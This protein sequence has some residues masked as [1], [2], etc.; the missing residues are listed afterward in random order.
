M[1]V[2]IGILFL[3]VGALFISFQLASDYLFKQTQ[4]VDYTQKIT[5]EMMA[6]NEEK[7]VKNDF[8]AITNVTALDAFTANKVE[9]EFVVGRLIVPS[10]NRDLP[11]SKG[12]NDENLFIGVA[13]MKAPQKLGEG[14]FVVAGHNHRIEGS[15]LQGFDKVGEGVDIY[16]TNKIKIYHYTTYANVLAEADAFE[17][18][19]DDLSKERGKP[20]LT[21]MTCA[22]PIVDDNRVFLLAELVDEQPYSE[23]AIAKLLSEGKAPVQ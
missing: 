19:S 6:E 10:M 17:Y 12:I 9:P 7:P 5:A 15:L 23:E 22:L 18:L 3:L 11:I 20:I 2:K 14:N 21:L 1:K 4:N 13:T 8:E 16:A